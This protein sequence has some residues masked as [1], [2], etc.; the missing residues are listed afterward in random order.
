MSSG[1]LIHVL[2]TKKPLLIAEDNMQCAA[3]Q[4][5]DSSITITKLCLVC[6]FLQQ[7]GPSCVMKRVI[8]GLCEAAGS[9]I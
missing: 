1:R 4:K 5:M 6:I 8:T 7:S 2:S 3:S 9:L